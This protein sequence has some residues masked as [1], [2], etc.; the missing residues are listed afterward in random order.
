MRVCQQGAVNI[1]EE[2][3]K[4]TKKILHYTGC[5]RQNLLGILGHSGEYFPNLILISS[6]SFKKNKSSFE[7][8]ILYV[9]KPLKF[10]FFSG[11]CC[12][13]FNVWSLEIILCI[14]ITMIYKSWGR[15]SKL[16]KNLGRPISIWVK[17]NT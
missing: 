8:I 12:I 10:F 15:K 7:N 9:L 6:T 2:S 16:M 17:N 3:T 14:L 1:K 11:T 4:F 13:N 5:P